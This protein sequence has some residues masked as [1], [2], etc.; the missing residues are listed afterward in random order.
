MICRSVPTAPLMPFFEI[1]TMEKS[2][3][4]AMPVMKRGALRGS[5]NSSEISVP[6]L[7]GSFVLRMLS[8]M[9]FSRTGKTVISCS[10]CAP[11]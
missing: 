7:D 3:L 8:G 5:L 1:V 6:G 9:F 11:L 2:F 4:P 10:T